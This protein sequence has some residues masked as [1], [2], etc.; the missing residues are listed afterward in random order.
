M[1]NGLSIKLLFAIAGVFA[2]ARMEAQKVD[3]DKKPVTT[4]LLSLPLKDVDTSL[5][6]FS[7][8]FAGAYVLSSCGLDAEAAKDKYFKLEGYTPVEADG[9]LQLETTLLPVRFLESKIDSRTVKTKDKAGRETSQTFYKHVLSYESGLTWKMKDKSGNVFSSSVLAGLQ[10]TSVKKHNGQEYGTYKD[11]SDSY[12]KNRLELTRNITSGEAQSL[13][14]G[15]FNTVNWQFGYKKITEK[16]NIW[17]VDS[18]NHPEFEASQKHYETVKVTFGIMSAS[19]LTE[20]DLKALQPAI[21]YYKS[22]PDK[23]KADE[24]ADTKLRYAAYFNLA[25]IYLFIDNLDK[26]SEY[27]NLLIAND[28]DKGDGKDFLK[29][30]EKLKALLAKKKMT[31]RRIPRA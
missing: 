1:Q 26:A 4:N 8:K 9:D 19:G 23:Y 5:H 16:F 30:A 15:M 25:N 18:K 24:K 22:I 21:D 27:A 10:N 29:D 17:I 20:A 11:A 6:C 7:Y 2:I 14:D 13:L 12:E 31:S 3:I 28:Y